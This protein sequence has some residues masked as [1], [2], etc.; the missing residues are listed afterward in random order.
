M[1]KSNLDDHCRNLRFPGA[2]VI[3]I[4]SFAGAGVGRADGDPPSAERRILS[5]DTDSPR[6][7]FETESELIDSGYVFIDGEYIQPPY[8][9][10]LSD[11]QV[12]I[13]G[14][15]IQNTPSEAN[16]RV[17]SRGRGEWR[18]S[19]RGGRWSPLR[20]AGEQLEDGA[21]IVVFA[22]QPL[23]IVELA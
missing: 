8:R 15:P 23:A 21:V 3:C 5:G 10:R 22:D 17:F 16:R 6:R 12:L 20:R 19:R 2:V 9:V 11:T 18:G 14:H 1:V 4:V 7:E 13:N